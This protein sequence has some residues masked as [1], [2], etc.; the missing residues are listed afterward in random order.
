MLGREFAATRLRTGPRGAAARGRI[1]PIGPYPS[2]LTADTFGQVIVFGFSEPWSSD[3]ITLPP[4][5]V[6]QRATR[7][8]STPRRPPRQRFRSC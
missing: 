4:L 7:A 5:P 2:R 8:V 3:P 1:V 6:Q